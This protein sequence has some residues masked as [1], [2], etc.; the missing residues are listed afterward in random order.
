MSR[1]IEIRNTSLSNAIRFA[2]EH[3]VAWARDPAADGSNWGI[4]KQ[5]RPPWNQLLGP[6]H[7]RGPVSGVIRQ[8]G[9]ELVSWGEPERCDLTFSVAKTYLALLTGV[10]L[11]QG[12]IGNVHE[13]VV[14]RVKRIGFENPQNAPVTWAQMLQQTSEWQGQCWGVPDQVDHFRKLQFQP[15]TP[16]GEK[17][18]LRRLQRPGTYWE[19]NDVRINQLSYALLHLFGRS[20]PEVFRDSITAPIGASADWQWIGYEYS[21]ITINGKRVQSVPGGTHWGGGMSIGARDQ[22][23]IGQLLLN[24]GQ[25]AGKQLLSAE[26]IDAMRAPCSI[27][28]WYGYLLWLNQTQSV[29]PSLPASAYAAYGAGG[30]ITCVLPEQ[31]AVVVVRWLDASHADSFL[32]LALNALK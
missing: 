5:D 15:N 14:E 13:P 30:S 12:L 4:H 3:E 9:E 8:G 29:F 22:A 1:D 17:G 25:W 2:Q 24:R 6:V 21:W 20:L 16:A 32:A 7:A 10:A 28:P 19:Y 27:A 18:D 26:W 31:D 11:D 23:L